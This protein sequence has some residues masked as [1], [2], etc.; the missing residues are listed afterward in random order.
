[1]P[2]L[3]DLRLDVGYALRSLRQ[4]PG[5]AAFALLILALGVSATTVMFTVI[6]GVLLRPL[7]Y[8]NPDRLLV[9]HSINEGFGEV[10][11]FSNPDITDIGRSSRSLATAEWTYGG[12]TINHAGETEYVQGRLIS[13]RLLGVLGVTPVQGRAFRPDENQKG[14]PPVAMISYGLWQRR[15][16]GKPAPLIYEGKPYTVV[17]ILPPGF[18][19]EGEADVF[20]P[21]GQSIDPRMENRGARFIHLVARLESG[22]SPREAQSEIA[23]IGRQLSQQYPGTN[24]GTAWVTRPMRDEVVGDVGSTL[25][26]LL[27]AVSLVLGVACVNIAS[28]LLARAVSR[29][30]EFAM[31]V[32]LGAS[33]GRLARQCLTEGMVLGLTGGLLGVWIAAAAVR[34]FVAFWPGSLPRAQEVGLDWSVLLFAFAV[35]LVSGLASGLAPALRG[36]ARSPAHAVRSGSSRIAGGTRRLHS[37]FVIAEIVLAAVLLVSAGTVGSALITLSGRDSG[38]SASNVLVARVAMAP[39]LI[40]TPPR[41]RTA[42]RE[43][44]DRAHG[45]P[46]IASAALSDIIPMREGENNVSYWST[47]VEPPPDQ[48]P[49][50]LASAVTPE[51][52]RV[53][54]IPLRSGR[55]LETGDSAGTDRVVVIDDHLARHAFGGAAEAIGKRLWVPSFGDDPVRIVGVVGHVRHWGLADDDQSRVRDQ[56]YYAFAQLP[57][58]LMPVFSSFMSIAVRT[59]GA[60]SGMVEPFQHSVDGLYQ[61]QTMEQLVHASLDRQRFLMMLFGIFAGLALLLA[62]IGI[63]GVLAYLTNQRV[64]EIGVRMALGATAADVVRFVFKESLGMILTG[65]LIGLVAALGAGRVVERLVVGAKP[66]EMLTIALMMAV[67]VATAL[68]ATLLPA[69]WASRIDPIHA[70]RRE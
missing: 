3:D 7:P 49:V 29:D 27:A 44:L 12:G 37:T 68:L 2:W 4:R 69:R 65:A 59:N 55:F 43:V 28:L 8:P 10:W 26:L 67:L 48:V 17:G 24:A 64:S 23:L 13:A 46:G 38:L 42:W 22:F 18:Q 45:V 36:P 16:G 9:V 34:P 66:N 57:D 33:R 25:W 63:Y 32:A 20:T 70:L 52:Q 14:G 56:M 30:R 51:Y 58:K 61:I 40:V 5:F 60:P 6:D 19:L 41:A 21:L 47:P 39:S 54:G 35:S 50:A 53:M 62:G 11:G 1:M 31:R 15:F